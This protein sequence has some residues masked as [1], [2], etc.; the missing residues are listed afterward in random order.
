MKRRCK[1]M[2]VVIGIATGFAITACATA[3]PGEPTTPDT[4]LKT[5]VQIATQE[6]LADEKRIGKLLGLDIVMLP[7]PP[8]DGRTGKYVPNGK[9]I[10]SPDYILT[11]DAYFY[12]TNGDHDTVGA[13]LNLT[14]DNRKLC[15]NY[16]DAVT[17]FS[18]YSELKQYFTM[19]PRL[20]PGTRRAPTEKPLIPDYRFNT[21]KAGG[22][23]FSSFTDCLVA[24]YISK[25]T[26][27]K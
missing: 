8:K 20:P 24:F 25:P 27:V 23:L 14:F 7:E 15:I 11:T 3:Q 9:A 1:W 19:H 22:I 13:T 16:K 21:D 26:T 5:L 6:D 10:S 2:S 17:E 4:V 12:Y 18:K